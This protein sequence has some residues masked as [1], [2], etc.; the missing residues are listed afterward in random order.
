[1]LVANMQIDVLNVLQANPVVPQTNAGE[2]LLIAAVNQA[3]AYLQSIGFLAGEVW[4][5]PTILNLS[6]GQTLPDGYLN[7]AQS[8]AQQSSAN[9]DAGQ[10]MPIYSAITTA[11]AVQSLLIGV[12]VQL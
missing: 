2:S 8:Y 5:G 10:A 1:M 11:G 6:T 12:N 7:Q 3:C 4:E 9:R